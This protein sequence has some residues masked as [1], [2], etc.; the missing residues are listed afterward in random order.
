MKLAIFFIALTFVAAEQ[1]LPNPTTPKLKDYWKRI[2]LNKTY[3]SPTDIIP[4]A[5]NAVDV[6]VQDDLPAARRVIK[7]GDRVTRDLH[8]DRINLILDD[9]NVITKVEFY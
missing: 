7:P 8:V 5:F 3:F 4:T 6:I 9:K 1:I 2:L